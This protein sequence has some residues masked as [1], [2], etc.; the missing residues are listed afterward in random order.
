MKINEIPISDWLIDQVDKYKIV[1][2]ECAHCHQYNYLGVLK[3]KPED[4]VKCIYCKK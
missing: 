2:F 1:E 4:E 3:D